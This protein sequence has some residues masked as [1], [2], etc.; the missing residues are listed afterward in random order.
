MLPFG[1]GNLFIRER[2]G[3]DKFI[4]Q[5]IKPWQWFHRG[6]F[7]P[8]DIFKGHAANRHPPEQF[9]GAGGLI[10]LLIEG[11]DEFIDDFGFGEAVGVLLIGPCAKDRR[12]TAETPQH[13]V[14]HLSQQVE[15]EMQFVRVTLPREECPFIR[16]DP[17]LARDESQIGQNPQF[18]G[19]HF[20]RFLLT[21]AIVVGRVLNKSFGL[22][23]HERL[24]A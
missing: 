4:R 2:I 7:H 15:D 13:L 10:E 12:N 23:G 14:E 1:L 16:A 5:L 3:P 9:P 8:R 17:M 11:G 6:I 19:S 24:L 20:T 18:D 21:E 22:R